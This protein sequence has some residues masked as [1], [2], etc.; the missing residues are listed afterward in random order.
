MP[1]VTLY[2][3]QNFIECAAT[4]SITRR[5]FIVAG[6]QASYE[7]DKVHMHSAAAPAA[8]E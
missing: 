1:Y 8:H 6:A 5:L 3:Q 7:S 4:L 2:C